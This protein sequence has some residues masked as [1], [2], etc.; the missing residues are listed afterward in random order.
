MK[1]IRSTKHWT[2]KLKAATPEEYKQRFLSRIDKGF[3]PKGC[4]VWTGTL[5][6]N[7]Y[8]VLW[9]NGKNEFT[10]RLAYAYAK[11]SIAPNMEVCHAC[12]NPS[13]VRPS[14]LF[15]GTHDKNM[16]DMA[17]K[18]RSALGKRNGRHTHP[19]TTARGDRSGARL[20]PDSYPRGSKHGQ[21]KLTEKTVRVI[22]SLY[23]TGLY[24]QQTIANQFSVNQTMVGFIVRRKVWTHI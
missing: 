22:R 1:Q 2:N 8:G 10:H 3:H 14:H 4:W 23:R 19:E 24:S 7:R 12:D 5:D 16:K 21:A 13:C 15:Q 17:T 20:H 6:G 11:G 9:M 18:K